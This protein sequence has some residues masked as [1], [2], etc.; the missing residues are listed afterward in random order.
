M[1]RTR[2]TYCR[3]RSHQ[4]LE[5]GKPRL[6]DSNSDAICHEEDSDDDCFFSLGKSDLN[7]FESEEKKKKEEEDKKED[8]KDK[9]NNNDESDDKEYTD[10]GV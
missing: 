5:R 2:F 3:K 10:E 8:N 4:W 6:I 9:E 1:A 7:S